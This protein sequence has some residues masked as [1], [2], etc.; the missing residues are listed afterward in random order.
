M[1][2]EVK[3]FIVRGRVMIDTST[4]REKNPNYF[5]PHLNEKKSSDDGTGFGLF[6]DPSTE[7]NSSGDDREVTKRKISYTREELLLCSD[8]VYGFSFL[9]RRW[10]QCLTSFSL[11]SRYYV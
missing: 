11:G 7:D 10:G 8:T 3:K 1:K 9:Q 6:D 5:V 2:K 4:F